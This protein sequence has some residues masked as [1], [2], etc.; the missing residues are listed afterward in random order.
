MLTGVFCFRND[1]RLHDN[2]TLLLALQECDQLY[3]VY[4]FEDRLWKGKKN[5]RISIHRAKFILEALQCLVKKVKK[6]GSELHFVYGDINESIPR[7]MEEVGAVI[8]FISEENAYEE[9][10]SEDALSGCVPLRKG[11]GKTLIHLH[12]LPCRLIDLPET[13][14]KFRI[15]VEKDLQISRCVEE[16]LTLHTSKTLNTSLP[17]LRELG[18]PGIK[19][20]HNGYYS[21]EGGVEG[22]QKRVQEWIW[23]KHCI[24]NYKSTRNQLKGADFSSRFSPWLSLGCLS[25]REIFWAVKKY[26]SKYS[27]NESTYWLIFEL[28]WRD[29][30]QFVAR[31]HG[32]KIF[33]SRGIQPERPINIE[34]ADAESLFSKWKMGTTSEPFINA[35]MN[36]LRLTGWMSNRGRQ[37]V[38]SYLINNLG[39]DWRRGAEW[40]EEQLIDYDPCSNYGNWLYLAGYGNDPRTN[41]IFNVTKQSEL[42]DP[43]ASYQKDWI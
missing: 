29:F 21:Y 38:A 23:E 5:K 27:G 9:K 19:T 34:P 30:F 32:P 7:F 37:I 39:L 14:S 16:P 42:Y 4:P 35:N 40:F 12:D 24:F 43:K 3:L 17:S 26:E 11:Y 13:F 33:H 25:P 41:R 31:T 8:C 28:L 6:L 36:E 18:F 15:L 20:N 1:L 22:G 10:L 2:E